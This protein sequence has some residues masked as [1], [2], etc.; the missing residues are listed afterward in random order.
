MKVKK[1][2]L[3]AIKLGLPLLPMLDKN[4]NI[5][6]D[7]YMCGDLAHGAFNYIL[8]RHGNA[9]VSLNCVDEDGVIKV[10]LFKTEIP[11]DLDDMIGRAISFMCHDLKQYISIDLNNDS[12]EL[13]K[14][15]ELEDALDKMGFTENHPLLKIKIK[16]KK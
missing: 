1:N 14:V 9:S 2:T 11:N 15:N 12:K 13:A 4:L 10:D 5:A 6:H 3:T 8:E 7:E 16:P